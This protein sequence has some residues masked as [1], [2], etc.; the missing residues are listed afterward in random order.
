MEQCDAVILGTAE[1]Y[2]TEA[3]ARITEW[4]AETSREVYTLGHLLPTSKN[5]AAGEQKQSEKAGEIALFIRGSN[6]L[7][8]DFLWFCFLA[9]QAR[10]GLGI[11]RC[12]HGKERA[13]R[14]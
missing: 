3:I 10:E 7:I 14:K 6:A 4:F 2:E 1:P 13:I 8:I 9:D 11:P 5:A 12:G